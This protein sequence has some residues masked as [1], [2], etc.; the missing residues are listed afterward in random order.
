MHTPLIKRGEK[1]G[2]EFES[3]QDGD[4]WLEALKGGKGRWKL[5]DYNIIT[6]NLGMQIAGLEESIQM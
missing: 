2:R 3:E 6:K 5:Y 4:T 1:K